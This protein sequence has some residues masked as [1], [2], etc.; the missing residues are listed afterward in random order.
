M[1]SSF[2]LTANF[3]DNSSYTGYIMHSGF[4]RK[5]FVARCQECQM[6]T[7][8]ANLNNSWSEMGKM[9]PFWAG[10]LSKILYI[11]PLRFKHVQLPKNQLA[12]SLTTALKLIERGPNMGKHIFSWN[13]YIWYCHYRTILKPNAR[14]CCLIFHYTATIN[15]YTTHFCITITFQAH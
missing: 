11:D 7:S 8:A 3:L 14:Q 4:K 1:I 2:A 9:S 10:H 15:H 5:K 6:E 13:L 12:N